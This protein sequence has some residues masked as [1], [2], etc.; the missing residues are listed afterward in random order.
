MP[1]PLDHADEALSDLAHDRVTGA[2]VL[3]DT[4]E[5]GR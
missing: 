5:Q 4:T 2:A 3:V 1:Y